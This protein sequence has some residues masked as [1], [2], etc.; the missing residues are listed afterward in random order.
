[1]VVI[2]IVS[3]SLIYFIPGDVALVI[4]GPGS[5]SK[6]VEDIRAELN[7]DK[8]FYSRYYL[9]LK[10]VLSGDLGR[11][12]ITREPISQMIGFRLLNTLKLAGAG[13]AFA[14][15]WGILLGL[16][17]SIKRNSILDY[18]TMAVS[19]FGISMPI[20]WIGLML[21]FFFSIQLRWFPVTGQGSLR[22]LILPSITIGLNSIAIIARITRSSMLEVLGKDYIRTA[23]AKGCRSSVVIFKHALKN[24]MIPIITAI[25]LQFGYLMGGAVLTETVFA[26]PGIG[27]L[28]ADSV[29]RRDFPVLQILML[30]LAASFAIVNFLV[31]ISYSFFDPRVEHK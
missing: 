28:F 3:F 29:F 14:V 30:T 9:W 10:S 31:D 18:G 22:H 16:V 6:A 27:R 17:A 23:K 2:S 5:S 15:F 8:P 21:I 20:F 25:G 12:A 26:W 7:L 24:A 13:V 1:M 11:S 4:A 19:I